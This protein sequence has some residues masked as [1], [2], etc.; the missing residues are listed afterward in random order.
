ML[1]HFSNIFYQR[2]FEIKNTIIRLVSTVRT[3]ICIFNANPCVLICTRI[4]VDWNQASVQSFVCCELGVASVINVSFTDCKRMFWQ[5]R[6]Q[7]KQK[8][9]TKAYILKV[10]KMV[11]NR[12]LVVVVDLIWYMYIYI[13]TFIY[14]CTS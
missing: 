3:S 4:S 11:C 10:R 6:F 9:T 1:L 12:T 7:A 2:S 14:I 13:H 8:K 5:M